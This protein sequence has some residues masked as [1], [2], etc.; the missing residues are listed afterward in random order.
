MKKQIWVCVLLVFAMLLSL[1]ATAFAA[2]DDDR[3]VYHATNWND[4]VDI[5]SEL[6]DGEKV[7]IEVDGYTI[8]DI[9]YIGEKTA[10]ISANNVDI[11]FQQ[12]N[13]WKDSTPRL[14]GTMFHIDGDD[15]TI[16]FNWS[17]L[18][19]YYG[20]AVEVDGD[21]CTILNA[22]FRRCKNPEGDGAGIHITDN[23]PGCVIINCEFREC[24]AENGGGIFIDSNDASIENCRFL[25]CKCT[26]K[27]KGYDIYDNEHESV[28]IDC[29]TTSS[30]KEAFINLESVTD[31]QF[32]WDGRG[33]FVSE[34]NLWIIITV[35]VVVI[36]VSALLILK[37][38]KKA[39]I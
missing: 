17:D 18:E 1:S 25:S 28:A 26:E 30:D 8:T 38:K 20:S 24:E 12:R 39:A 33:S 21:N 34:G 4:M 36:G 27:G 7:K 16:N 19:S 5:L 6:E 22:F 14:K 10:Y 3:T 37:K 2:T 11:L 29:K 35:A 32:G 13:F 31:C 9:V 15:V 23:D